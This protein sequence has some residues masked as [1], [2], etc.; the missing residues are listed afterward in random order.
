M[1][2]VIP[3]KYQKIENNITKYFAMARGFQNPTLDVDVPAM[4]MK[5]WFDT[6]CMYNI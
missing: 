5:K 3:E 6:N 2:G 1:F 4:E